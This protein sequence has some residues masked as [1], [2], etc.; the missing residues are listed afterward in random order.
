MQ[1]QRFTFLWMSQNSSKNIKIK[2]Q[3]GVNIGK[4][5]VLI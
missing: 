1:M 3:N 2:Y 4:E 5:N